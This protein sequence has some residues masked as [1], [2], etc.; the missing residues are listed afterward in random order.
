VCFGIGRMDWGWRWRPEARQ[1]IAAPPSSY[2]GRFFYDSITH[3]ERALRYLVDSVGIG[4][5]LFGTDFPGFASGGHGLAYQP[6]EWVR[7]LGSLTAD[8]KT[9]ILSTN[10][11]RVFGLAERIAAGS[12]P[13]PPR[14]STSRGATE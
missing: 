1:F 8:E 4:Q 12:A 10:A 6:V 5:V 2:L 7:G 13:A 9:A 3:D 14:T 11:E